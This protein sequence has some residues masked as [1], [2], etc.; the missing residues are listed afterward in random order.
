MTLKAPILIAAGF[1]VSAAAGFVASS[2]A[3]G[4][5]PSTTTKVMK[6]TPAPDMDMSSQDE[7]SSVHVL[8]VNDHAFVVVKDYGDAATTMYFDTEAGFPVL[9]GGAKKYFY[10]K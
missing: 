2:L 3:Q 7:A 4:S 9:K 1:V 10:E 5:K 6:A 8:R